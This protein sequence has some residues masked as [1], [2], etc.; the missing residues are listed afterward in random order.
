M[1]AIALV[2]EGAEPQEC[3]PVSPGRFNAQVWQVPNSA[4][5]A[6]DL[7]GRRQVQHRLTSSRPMQSI[8]LHFGRAAGRR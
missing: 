1:L 2:L 6:T 7:T 3:P 4:I 8:H 5:P